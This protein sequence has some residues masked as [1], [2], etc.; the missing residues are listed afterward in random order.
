MSAYNSSIDT[1]PLNQCGQFFQCL[2]VCAFDLPFGIAELFA[3]VDQ[4]PALE[5][6]HVADFSLDLG[7]LCP[8]HQIQISL[9]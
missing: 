8:L 6:F 9:D 7:E 1:P 5:I 3:D 2:L 4:P